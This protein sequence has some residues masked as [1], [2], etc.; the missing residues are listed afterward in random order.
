[1]S[2]RLSFRVAG[3]SDV[4]AILN[5]INAAFAVERFFIDGDRVSRQDVEE[6]LVSGK[7][8][9]AEEDGQP[10]G[11]VWI[12][13]RGERA[14]LGLLSVNPS[15]QG[16]GFGT[17]LMRAAEDLARDHGCRFMD[18]RIV[19]LRTELP[20]FYRSLGYVETGTAPFSAAVAPSIP[21]HFVEMTKP[22]RQSTAR[23]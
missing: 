12:E 5:L 2:A 7:F 13:L 18:L 3:P 23:A 4:D 10:L 14:Y 9:L 11:C 20:P 17:R 8:L 21:C 16:K 1:M 15:L 6:R 22:L 19:N